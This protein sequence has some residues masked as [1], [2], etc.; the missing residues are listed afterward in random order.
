MHHTWCIVGHHIYGHL[1]K[2][3]MMDITSLL[4]TGSGASYMNQKVPTL[5]TG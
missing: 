2:F 1:V 5:K 4:F 3:I